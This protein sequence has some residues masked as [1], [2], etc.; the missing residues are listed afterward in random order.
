MSDSLYL[1][2]NV[3]ELEDLRMSMNGYCNHIAFIIRSQ[4][5]LQKL[6]PHGDRATLD[7]GLS[8]C[9]KVSLT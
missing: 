3:G 7:N 2:A 8:L 6:T 1:D 4:K 5:C 9:A